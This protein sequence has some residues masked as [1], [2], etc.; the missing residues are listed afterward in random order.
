MNQETLR[1][2]IEL[3]SQIFPNYQFSQ[4]TNEIALYCPSCG[5]HKRKLMISLEKDLFHCW[6]CD[7]GGHISKLIR[8]YGNEII[9]REWQR[10]IGK[11]DYDIDLRDFLLGSGAVSK[12]G[13]PAKVSLP[14]EAIKLTTGI[15]SL[16]A[17]KCLNFLLKRGLSYRTIRM[18]NLHY[19]EDGKYRDRVIIPS[20]DG[21]GQINFFV[22]RSI[23]DATDVTKYVHP[24]TAKEDIIFNEL[25]VTWERPIV[26]V[27]GPFDAIAVNRNAVPLLGSAL[28]EKSALFK[29]I[30]NAKPEV[31]LML[32]NDS[33]GQAG[34]VKAGR[35]L[36]D[37]GIT[38]SIAAYSTKDPGELSRKEIFRAIKERKQFTQSDVMRRI[39]E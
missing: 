20:Y 3:I 27:E 10:A 29:Q 28:S 39:L 14:P 26:L 7:Y 15:P 21:K 5:H 33:P 6:V 9:W 32:D 4:S 1:I 16:L 35:I 37:W 12:I 30:M 38:T 2:K 17:K 22:A 36:T 25:L 18:Y 13:Q 23:Y 19:A 24:Q 34:T 11:L 31:I 8:T